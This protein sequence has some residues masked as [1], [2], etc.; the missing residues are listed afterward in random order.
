[1]KLAEIASRLGCR[2]E[3]DGEIEI[4]GVA[5]IEHA[6]RGQLT[7]LANRKYTAAA[8]TSKASAILVAPEAGPMPMAALRSENPYLDFARSIEL[9]HQ[10]ARYAPGVHPTAVVAP[11][12]RIAPDAH[13]GPYCFV[14]DEVE[15][16]SRAVLHSFVSIYRGARIGDDFF[17][18]SHVVV[19]EDCQIGNRVILQ[20]SAIVG[21]DGFGFARRADGTWHKI[22]QSGTVVV[23]D[24]VE[25]QAGACVDR[26]TIGETR[27]CRGAKLDDL[28]L[29]GHSSSV[30]EDS[31]LCG[32]VGLAGSTHVGQRCVLAGQVGAAGHLTIGDGAILTAQS[33]VPN[34]VP[35]GATYSGYPAMEN[36]R[37]LKCVAVV[38]QLPEL[39]ATVRELKAQ[40]E[41]LKS[42]LGSR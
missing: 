36:K 13:I 23:E 9:F 38:H 6:A 20:N 14:D 19:R 31:L 28:V 24:D 17:A 15:L 18:H 35:A 25:I 41:E 8:R 2:L 26:A 10:P 16:G 34:D 5:G 7:F 32:Q 29:V 40:M 33:G 39:Q 11:G 1:M 4:T 3:G 42:R 12:A 22:L 30:G 37:W 21:A 27:I